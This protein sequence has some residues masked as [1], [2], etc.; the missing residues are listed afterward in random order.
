MIRFSHPHIETPMVLDNSS[1][2]TLRVENP[3]E[4]YNL[5]EELAAIFN[6]DES[7]FSF[8]NDD[9]QV[10]PDKFGELIISPFYFEATDKKII[11]L[12]YKKLQNNYLSGDFLAEF[13]LIN[14]KLESFLYDLCSTVSFALDHNPLTIEDALKA[15]AVKPSKTY[16]TLIEKLVCYINIFIELKS[17]SFFVLVGFKDVLSDEELLQLFKHCELHKV[18]L[19]FLESGKIRKT[20]AEERKIIITED[21]CE[22]VEN[23]EEKC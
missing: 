11:S 10:A 17:I 1:P 16:D 14:A 9:T 2:L 13:N 19:F 12:L 18:S 8:W 22:I 21:L 6:G 3:K 4:Y 15:C 20:L 5:A 7:G 23:I